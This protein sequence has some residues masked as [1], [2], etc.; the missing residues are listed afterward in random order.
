[1]RLGIVCGLRSEKAALGPIEHPVMISGADAARAYDHAVALAD[2]G[3]ECLVSIG[4]AGAIEAGLRAGDLLLPETVLDE[5]GHAFR[6][7]PL[8]QDLPRPAKGA[9]ILG[10]DRVIT[11]SQEKAALA[12]TFG[13]ASVDM[14]S[15]VVARAAAERHLPFYVVRAVADP[16]SQGLPPAAHGAIRRDGSIDTWKTVTQ[17]A[18]RP[19][20][21]GPLI[22]L[23]R[24]SAQAH[25]TLRS[26]GRA[27]LDAIARA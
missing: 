15:H 7:H 17:L 5:G 20:D 19:Q 11:S 18:K 23:G 21:L 2:G 13:A 1:M 3:A 26:D 16:A 22:A 25:E 14:E 10:V 6:T 9:P 24:Q 4:L 8:S 27:I 12:E